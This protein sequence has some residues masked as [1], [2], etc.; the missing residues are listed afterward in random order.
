MDVNEVFPDQ[1]EMDNLFARVGVD[2]D[3]ARVM[4]PKARYRF[5]YIRG[6]S[7]PAANILKQEALS[8]GAE[9]AVSIG[10]I[11]CSV[12]TTDALLW[13]DERRLSLLADKISGQVYGLGKLSQ[14][15]SEAMARKITRW[16][17]KDKEIPLGKTLIMGAVNV[18]PD[19]FYGGGRCASPAEATLRGLRMAEDGANM[20]DV[21]GESTRPGADPVPE[22]EELGRVI[23]VIEKLR[24]ELGP[25]FILSVDTYK[26]RVAREALKAGA[27]IVNDIS[28]LGF[29]EKMAGV[30]SETGAGLVIM[31]MKGTPK[32]MQID[33]QYED[34]VSEIRDYLHDGLELARQKG[35]DHERIA[36]DPGI[37]FGKRVCD[38]LLIL[39]KIPEFRAVGRPVVIGH[40]RKSFIGRVL[41]QPDAEKR[42]AGS[43][44][45]AAIASWLGADVIRTHD[46]KETADA[47]RMARAIFSP[48]DYQ[49]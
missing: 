1:R 40:S 5:F 2:P 46:V 9:A 19:S 3:G 36:L 24:T 8:Y 15:V 31:H 17:A 26:A 21:G 28:G 41:G 42:L 18:T 29:D 45:V 20:I 14:L 34:T 49:S 32:D 6:L 11:N 38:N 48:E 27:D 23:P 43:V 16:V 13:G 30:V 35:I 33:P 44:G 25:D 12:R 7:A 4:A 22:D 37:G 39:R 47:V 10:V